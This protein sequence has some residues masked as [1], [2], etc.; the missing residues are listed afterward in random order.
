MRPTRE[1]TLQ[2]G[3]RKTRAISIETT[4]SNTF[5]KGLQKT[6]KRYQNLRKLARRNIQQLIIVRKEKSKKD[7][8]FRVNQF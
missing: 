8:R 2:G 4:T 3:R 1:G 6:Q 5:Q 7:L